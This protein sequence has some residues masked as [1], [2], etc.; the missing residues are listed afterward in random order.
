LLAV[1]LT[2]LSLQIRA[3]IGK[4]SISALFVEL[5][6]PH[7]GEPLITDLELHSRMLK[8]HNVSHLVSGD[9]MDTSHAF[10][11]SQLLL[12]AWPICTLVALPFFVSLY[13]RA[14]NAETFP[15]GSVPVM[16]VGGNYLDAQFA[17]M[18]LVEKQLEDQ[19][20]KSQEQQKYKKELLEGGTVSALDLEAPRGAVAEFNKAAELL[21]HQ[22]AADAVAHLQTAISSYPKFVSAHNNLGL[23]Y[24]ETDQQNRARAEF[25]TAAKLDSKFAE[26]FL[27]I[28]KLDL[29]QKDFAAAESNLEKAA[30]IRPRDARILT[31]LA[32]A[33][34][35]VHEYHH[36]IDTAVR[37]HGL[38]HSGM[39]NVHYVAAASAIALK[40]FD[41][42]QRELELFL[43]E[44]PANPLAPSATHNLKVLASSK[45][46]SPQS[47]GSQ[48]GPTRVTP[49][50]VTTFPNSDALKRAL[51]SLGTDD[52]ICTDC[53]ANTEAM[54]VPAPSP[55][56][57]SPP[58]PSAI[59]M[60]GSPGAWRIREVI[61][62]VA[63]FFS[64]TNRGK[65]VDNLEA[66]DLAIRDDNKPPTKVLQFTP[67]S[68]L[69]LR[70]AL[71]VDTSGSLQPRFDFERQAASRF[72]QQMVGNPS[73]LA[74]VAGFS[75][76]VRVLQDFTS[77]IKQLATGIDDLRIGGGTAI[78]D[79]VSFACWKL[80]AYPEKE[81]VAKVLVVLTDGE[82]NLS[83]T[84]L[85]NAIR[86]AEN[87]G[88]TV[89]AISTKS[90]ADLGQYGNPISDADK[91]LQAL[92]ERTGG[93]ALF[94]G[95]MGTL[96]KSFDKL[97]DIIRSRYLI[98]YRPA[99]FQNDGRYRKINIV[100]SQN[101][102]RLKVHAR[103]GYYAA[104]ETIGAK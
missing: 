29:S 56:A 42:V 38:Q 15:T 27:N 92:A 72:I 16:N 33:Q 74:F 50:L 83:H 32:Y 79:A 91:V 68:K 17:R 41:V 64:V 65:L 1:A 40:D 85:R 52:D 94:P 58:T 73:D 5:E 59:T 34:N 4:P 88:V 93:E 19:K 37:V 95:D 23:A 96:N 35:G 63:V 8:T 31:V 100:A 101:G 3:G 87:T 45:T 51:A 30:A 53:D 60:G 76:E 44:D 61:D 71:L 75:D 55:A 39:A 84:S 77:D 9:S 21:Q 20:R 78:W 70:L 104:R 69:P 12:R 36:S 90:F 99:D 14:Q 81:R 54:S 86:D 25:E 2:K 62:E 28:G 102:R 97:R 48:G 89:Y 80:A 22:K 18:D 47:S 82:D 49:E 66:S 6:R 46:Q 67:Q 7:T 26:S 13:V 43:K 24:L 103:Q 10:R 57:S 98:A 11:R